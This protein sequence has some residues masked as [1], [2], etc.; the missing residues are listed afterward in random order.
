MARVSARCHCSNGFCVALLLSSRGLFKVS[1][2]NSRIGSRH[3]YPLRRANGGSPFLVPKSRR[4]CC[5]CRFSIRCRPA[6]KKDSV[7]SIRKS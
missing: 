6:K 3:L 1:D 5:A 2:T 4:A 7:S